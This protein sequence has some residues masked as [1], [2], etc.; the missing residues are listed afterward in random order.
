[1]TLTAGSDGARTGS[2]RGGGIASSATTAG[3]EKLRFI[4]E[5]MKPDGHRVGKYTFMLLIR[6]F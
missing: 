4:L 1:M 3:L 5:L 2:L 6:F